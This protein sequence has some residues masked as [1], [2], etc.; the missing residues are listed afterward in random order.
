MRLTRTEVLLVLANLVV[1]LGLF[2]C[3]L[4]RYPQ[5]QRLSP[6]R[7]VRQ[8]WKNLWPEHPVRAVVETGGVGLRYYY[9][10]GKEERLYLHC[11]N[12]FL[13]RPADLV[14]F[15]R[16]RG[17]LGWVTPLMM[18]E[19][20]IRGPLVPYRDLGLE[21]PPV[22]VPFLV[23][24]LL[25]TD[26]QM[27]Y[28]TGF[29]AEMGLVSLLAL[30]LTVWGGVRLKLLPRSAVGRV[31]ALSCLSA[32]FLGHL[33]TTRLDPGCALFLVL[34]LL[35]AVSHRPIL[36]GLSLSLAT[37]LKLV[38]ILTLPLFI[39]FWMKSERKG[40]SL[41]FLVSFLIFCGLIFIPP[42]LSGGERFW[43]MFWMH[44][45]RTVSVDSTFGS[46][47]ALHGAAGGEQRLEKTSGS[48]NVAG[49]L[50]RKLAGISTLLVLL[51]VGWVSF[52][53]FRAGPASGGGLVR[54]VL[55]LLLL[56]IFL[57]KVFSP[58]YLIWVW[59]W[60]FLVGEDEDWT[61]RGLFLV[62]ML[63]TQLVYPHLYGGL[64][65]FQPL[66]VGVLVS[67]NALLGFL[68]YRWLRPWLRPEPVESR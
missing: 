31:L 66:A 13:G 36:A 14:D 28:Y 68:C 24:P 54:A 63:L 2:N 67:R 20:P 44:G 5:G 3:G 32:L 56:S 4:D 62:L 53:F 22:N 52:L 50:A 55:A 37:G 47:L 64:K 7:E 57:G 29:A 25:L 60:V 1:F 11:A 9:A 33:F 49:P 34:S 19:E 12:L 26:S 23:A 8:R 27:G 51:G 21:Y 10:K 42:A 45:G 43:A 65:E 61:D 30:A 48:I 39:L 16:F 46:L 58:Q 18:P 17:E 41:K 38:P 15:K 6:G 59:P 40:D 35:A